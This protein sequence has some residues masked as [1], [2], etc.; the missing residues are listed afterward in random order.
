M[1]IEIM[2]GYYRDER[3]IPLFMQHYAP[4]AEKITFLTH[5]YTDDK[6]DENLRTQIANDAIQQSKA[7][8]IAYMDLDEFIFPAPYGADPR[9]ALEA[10]SRVGAN[11]IFCHMPRVWRHV[12]ERDL[13]FFA[14]PVPQR[15]HG[16]P[17]TDN[18]GESKPCLFR[19][20]SGFRVGIG[21]HHVHMPNRVDGLPWEGAHWRNADPILKNR[22]LHDRKPRV[23]A[24]DLEH[25]L[26]THYRNQTEASLTAQ[27]EEHSHDPVIIQL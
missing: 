10:E 8:W 17:W 22:I 11:V 26:C 23:S 1:Y 27:S 18:A 21:T 2:A 13:D 7:D 25:G 14:P 5:R 15:I 24:K 6:M 3:L 9:A 16:Q 20:N 12:S 4:W 19:P